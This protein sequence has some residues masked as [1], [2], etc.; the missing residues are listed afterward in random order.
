MEKSP[1][2]S[3]HRHRAWR[4]LSGK[5]TSVT[6]PPTTTEISVPVRR[7]ERLQQS[8]TIRAG[9]GPEMSSLRPVH[10]GRIRK[11]SN[12][13]TKVH[14]TRFTCPIQPFVQ[15]NCS[16]TGSKARLSTRPDVPQTRR[17][18]TKR[19]VASDTNLREDKRVLER[20]LIMSPRD[21]H[22]TQ[23]RRLVNSTL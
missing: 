4:A 1:R 22:H 21:G 7:S 3:E 2:K 18:P 11:V 10:S 12:V 9:H 15:K 23:A 5:I 13:K 19:N 14:T 17:I 6:V 16:I 20:H 8:K